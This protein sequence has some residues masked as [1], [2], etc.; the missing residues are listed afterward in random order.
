MKQSLILLNL[1]IPAAT[2]FAQVQPPCVDTLRINPY[3]TCY[4]EYNPVCGCDS[5]T[6]RNYCFAQSKAGVNYWRMGICNN[7]IFDIDIVPI[8]VQLEPF[9]FSAAFR[10]PSS[11]YIFITDVFGSV[12]YNTNI[13]TTYNDEIK[14]FEIETGNFLNGVYSLFAVVNGEKKFKKFIKVRY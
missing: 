3:H 9:I 5:I 4:I 8:P 12:V 11:C 2:V 6:H 1:L 7:Q 13:Y 14:S 10:I